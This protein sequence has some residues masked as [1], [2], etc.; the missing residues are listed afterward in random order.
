MV[1]S[2]AQQLLDEGK[3]VG[4]VRLKAG[5][6]SNGI[7]TFPINQLLIG[8]Q[9]APEWQK[10]NVTQAF[11]IDMNS[12]TQEAPARLRGVKPATVNEKHQRVFTSTS[13]AE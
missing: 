4:Q 5:R 11:Q 9:K 2:V 6:L 13:I 7:I 3:S 8:Y 10:A 1:N 12:L